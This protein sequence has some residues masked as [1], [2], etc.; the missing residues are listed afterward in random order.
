MS[1]QVFNYLTRK[2]QP[3]EPL[4]QGQ[5]GMYVCGPTVY[6][7]AHLGH[8]KLYV[9]MDVIVRYLRFLDYTVR[10]VQ[11]I[12]DVGHLLDTGEDRILKG[13]RRERVEP[14]EVVET[15]TRSYFEDMDALGVVR[16]NIS[17]RAS[18][19]V[20]EQIEIVK[21]LLDKGYAYVTEGGDV[22]FSVEKF[23][24]YGKLSGRR[25]EEQE[26]GARVSVREDKRHPADFALWKRAEPEHILRWPSPWGWGYPG[27]HVECTAMAMKYLGK[28]FDIHGGGLE[29]IFPHNECEIAQSEATTGQLFA[30]YW[31]LVGSL[32]VNGVKMSKSLGNFLT[33]KDALK[34]YSPWAIRLFIL[35][36]HYRGP[37]DFS[38]DAVLAAER[39]IERLH[40]TVRLVRS[41]MQDVGPSGTA[42]LSYVNRLMPIARQFMEAMDDDF[43]TPKAL[44]ILFDLNRE[45]NEL[46]NSRKPL[47]QGTLAAIDGLYRDLGSRVLGIIPE[48]LTQDIGGGLVEGLMAIILRIRRR[49]R[50]TKDWE[51]ADTLRQQLTELGI[52]VE[53]RPE[54][55][56]WR[57][58][59]ERG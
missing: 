11:N 23:A 46:L 38:R 5:V 13:A 40:A 27:W 52:V 39:G 43:N 25:L 26:A 2:K 4:E 53:D 16:P 6:D 30:R 32:T 50:E 7:H 22:Y 37:M 8:A 58:E 54:G 20:P 33:L 42:E 55:P 47:S 18:G 35:S 28:T 45:V 10:Y 14:M 49:Y 48:D 12:T 57:V 34:L 3:F 9:A 51:Q 44:A 21:T 41:R 31:I 15:Y 36:S 1:L 24:D 19:H 59:R 17:P 56:A 29:N